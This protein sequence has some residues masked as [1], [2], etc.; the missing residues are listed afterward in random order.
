MFVI[1]LLG[2]LEM[3]SLRAMS[4]MRS[5]PWL[6]VCRCSA[7]LSKSVLVVGQVSV[8]RAVVMSVFFRENL[9][10]EHSRVLAISKSFII[11]VA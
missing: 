3:L 7:K 1:V 2:D 10:M 6:R 5:L 4:M 11:T 8:L 9:G